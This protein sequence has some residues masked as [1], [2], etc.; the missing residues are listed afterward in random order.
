MEEE[1]R[2]PGIGRGTHRGLISRCL[3]SAERIG[4]GRGHFRVRLQF[5]FTS[6]LLTV[7]AQNDLSAKIIRHLSLS[8]SLSLS[9]LQRTA[10][11][12]HISLSLSHLQ[13]TAV[14][15]SLL[16]LSHLQK[17]AVYQSETFPT[18][19]SLSLSLSHL[20]KTADYRSNQFPK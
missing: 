2:W 15:F 13:R 14:S 17:T 20:Q 10:V 5:G 1:R 4:E 16:S 3:P 8:F 18:S 7:I 12:F 9:H 11:N 6:C 19:L